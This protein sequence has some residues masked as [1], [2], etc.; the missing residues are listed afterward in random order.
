MDDDDDEDNDPPETI[1]F[2]P[3][4]AKLTIGSLDD[5]S[6]VVEAQYN[7]KELQIKRA[8]PWTEHGNRAVEFTGTKGRTVS[9]ELLFDGY[10]DNQSIADPIDALEQ[11]STVRDANALD[12]DFQRPHR[13]VVTWGDSGIPTLRC[14]IESVATKYTMFDTMG[15]P[16]RAIATVELKEA[17]VVETSVQEKRAARARDK[18]MRDRERAYRGR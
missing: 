9:V 6:L 4:R 2:Q 11:L 16:L 18:E 13:C 8:V 12:E 10:E 5:N 3:A 17:N 7:P 14:V 1:P 15:T